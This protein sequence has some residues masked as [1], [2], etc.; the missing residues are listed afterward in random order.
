MGRA[1]PQLRDLWHYP[2]LRLLSELGMDGGWL[3]WAGVTATVVAALASYLLIEWPLL[4][5]DRFSVRKLVLVVA[6][7]R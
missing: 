7:A 3:L 6:A 5:R 4:R 2:V 1:Q